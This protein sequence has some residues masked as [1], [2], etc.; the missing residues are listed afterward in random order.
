MVFGCVG[1][2]EVV[3][4]YGVGGFYDVTDASHADS[5]VFIVASFT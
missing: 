5:Y 1:C 4:V 3:V 2:L